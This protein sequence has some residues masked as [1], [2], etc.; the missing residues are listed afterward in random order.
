ML[1]LVDRYVIREMIFPFLL[2]VAGFV[3][4]IILNLIPQLSDFMIDRNISMQT[5]FQMLFWRLPELLVYG[6]PVGVL[7]AI[8]WAL[9]RLSHDRELIALQAAGFSLRRLMLPVV[10]MGLIT[11]VTAFAVGELWTPWAN[12]QY[13]NLLREIFFMRSVPQIRESTFMKI[14]DTAYAYIERYDPTTKKLSHVMVFDKGG[15]EYLPELE[16]RFPKVIVAA[17]GLWDGEYWRLTDGKLHK[18]RDDGQFEY[19]V[20][21]AKLSLRAGPSLQRLLVE[22]RTPHEMSIAELSEQ[23]EVLQRSGLGAESLLVELHAKIAVPFSAL[24]F[25]LFGAPLSLIF[26]Q[27]GAPRGRAAGVIISVLLV[28]S[29]QGLLLWMS[30]LGKRGLIAPPLA[31]WVPNMLFG[32]LG[33]VLVIWLD[34]LSQLDLFARL[35]RLVPFVL[36]IAGGGTVGWAQEPPPISLD[37]RADRLT[38]ARDWQKLSA[39]GHV[40]LVY[41]KGSLHADRLNAQRVGESQ[42]WRIT[43]EGGVV[44]EG[45]GLKGEAKKIELQIAWD[46]SRWALSEA[47]LF[48]AR[49][50][51]ERGSLQAHEMFLKP[52]RSV[53]V[54]HAQRFLGQ[55]SFESAAKKRET[56]RFQGEEARATLSAEG[57]LKLLEIT[58]GE[59]TTCTCAE[60]ISRAA[61][62]IAAGSV[63]LEP[64]ES[65]WATNITLKTYGIPIFWAPVYF[66]SL[67]E[68]TKN[69]LLPDFGQLPDRGWYFR[70][71]LPF[72]VDRENTGTVSIDFYTKLPEVGMGIEYRYKFWEQQ[73]QISVYRLVGRGESWATDWAHQ[74]QL[75]F[76]TRLSVGI[77]WRTGLL[78]QEAQRLFSRVLLSGSFESVR[79]S[80]LWSR[81]QYLVLP[82][83]EE[84]VLYRFL[85][86]AP[87]LMLSLVPWRLG[88]LSVTFSASWGTYREKKLDRESLDESTRWDAV[89]GLQSLALGNDLLRI[90]A[91]THYR[92]SLYA[93]QRFRREAYDLTVGVSTH[94]VPG[95]SADTTYAYRRV[96][97]QSPFSFDTLDLMHHVRFRAGWPTAPFKPNLTWGYDLR[98]QTFE[99]LRLG[100]R[101]QFLGFATTIDLEYDLNRSLWHRA[102]LTLQGSVVQLSTAYLFPTRNFEDLIVKISW[103]VQ[104]LGMSIDLKRF[105]LQRLNLETSWQWWSEW[106]FSLKGEYDVAR[107]RWTAL[108]VGIIKKFCN[109]CWQLGVYSDSSR[110]WLQ[111]QINAFP[112][113]RVRYSPTDQRLSFGS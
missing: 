95:L 92:L 65:V 99:L 3:L 8:F 76:N 73:G 79:W 43:A 109:A 55:A 47:H 103:G 7:F 112:T 37:L 97:G 96:V 91:S 74:A 36:I 17:E 80:A 15:G 71:R 61:Y 31:P 14:S 83:S 35:R 5:L 50:E 19:T 82:E 52:E 87:E 11:T 58:K 1:R 49:I 51:Y 102:A 85:E 6:L 62:S 56:L 84:A 39:E 24:I 60:P 68:E 38:V 32:V 107:Q 69:P 86:K 41:E 108:Q 104:R 2:A 9:G 28:A 89:I 90:Q 21:F 22:Q 67:K 20:T 113:A 77:A 10:L 100:L 110:V 42:H 16:A 29:Y 70:W 48:T 25:A 45:E 59:I 33:V 26:A 23:I 72:V 18:L 27:G 81:D 98:Q 93:P 34:R 46:G 94:P 44:W 106:E 105:S 12:H 101:H 64:D 30:T 78:E 13:Y 40:R 57:Q 4:F 66:A 63:L 54:A 111:A 53:W 88:P 75:P